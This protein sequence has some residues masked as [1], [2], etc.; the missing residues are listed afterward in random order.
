MAV[1]IDNIGWGDLKRPR[2][3]SS[4]VVQKIDCV[5]MTALQP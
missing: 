3:W 4:T 1:D 5:T 2:L